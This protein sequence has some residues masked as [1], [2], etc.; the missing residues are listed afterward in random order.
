MRRFP[1]MPLILLAAMAQPAFAHPSTIPHTHGGHDFVNGWQHPF[2]G[3]DHLLAM[4][5]VGLLAVRIGGRALW[6]MPGAFLGSM[7]LG[8]I[9]AALGVPLPGVEFGIAASVLVLGLLIA[10]TKVV[11]L[12]YGAALVALFAFFHGHAHASE[13]ATGGSLAAYAAGFV[14]ATAVLHAAG[15][16]GGQL[17]VRKSGGAAADNRALR[18]TGGLI[19]LAGV[20]LVCGLI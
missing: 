11:P 8:G 4:V 16:L 6:L 3:L 2:S 7:V 14:L 19:S 13:M 12:T 18:W 20:L 5:A 10:V 15:V 1:L 17:L 9:V